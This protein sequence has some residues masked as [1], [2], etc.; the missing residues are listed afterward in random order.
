VSEDDALF[1]ELRLSK[2]VIE[3]EGYDANDIDDAIQLITKL[4]GQIADAPHDSNACATWWGPQSA[5]C[6]C[7]KAGL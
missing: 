4:R 7:W 3:H 1:T 2:G 5:V 6:T